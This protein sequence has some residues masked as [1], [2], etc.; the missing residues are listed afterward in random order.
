MPQ[1]IFALIVI[2][3]NLNHSQFNFVLK[4]N[5]ILL[6]AKIGKKSAPMPLYLDT[7]LKCFLGV[8]SFT[9]ILFRFGPQKL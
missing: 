6:D 7:R 2:Q 8:F 5:I 1:A 4:T 3:E 9:L